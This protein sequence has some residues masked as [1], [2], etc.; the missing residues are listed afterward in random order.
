MAGG[1]VLSNPAFRSHPLRADESPG[2]PLGRLRTT[3]RRH[4]LMTVNYADNDRCERRCLPRASSADALEA[5]DD[6]TRIPGPGRN[7]NLRAI[8]FVD[9]Y[10]TLGVSAD[11]DGASQRDQFFRNRSRPFTRPTSARV[12]GGGLGSSAP[13]RTSWASGHDGFM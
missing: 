12:D 4:P 6:S 5:Y 9:R 3:R 2:R 7:A 10:R 8:G 13:R 11:R 1:V